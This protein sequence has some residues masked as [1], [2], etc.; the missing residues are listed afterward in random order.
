MGR[1]RRETAVA[2]PH[3]HEEYEARDHHRQLEFLRQDKRRFIF[4]KGPGPGDS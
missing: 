3:E 4:I 1:D 2:E